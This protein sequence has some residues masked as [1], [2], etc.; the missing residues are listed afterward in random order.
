[1]VYGYAGAST[2][3]HEITHGFD[4]EGRQYDEKGNLKNWWTKDDAKNLISV[5]R[6]W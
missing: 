2:I 4:D 1:M 3:G 6:L 5:H